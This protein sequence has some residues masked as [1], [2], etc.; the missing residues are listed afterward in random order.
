MT[1]ACHIILLR[2]K[3]YLGCPISLLTFDIVNGQ[4]TIKGSFVRASLIVFNS[5]DRFPQI[6]DPLNEMK[7]LPIMH[8]PKLIGARDLNSGPSLHLHPNF[9]CASNE[10]SSSMKMTC[11]RMRGSRKFCQ[12]GSKSDFFIFQLRGGQRIHITLKA[13]HHG[14]TSEIIF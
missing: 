9:L 2:N 8:D 6:M 1:F 13:G 3:T 12:R 10:S 7:F 14:S 4:V 5:S 11:L